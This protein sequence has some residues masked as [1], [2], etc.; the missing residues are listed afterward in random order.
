LAAGRPRAYRAAT[1]VQLFFYASPWLQ[2]VVGW[3]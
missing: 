1:S 3:G 2:G